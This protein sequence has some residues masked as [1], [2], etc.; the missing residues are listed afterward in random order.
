ML[1]LLQLLASLAL[2]FGGGEL[3][4]RG[5]IALASRL[6]VS[7]L[8]IGLTVVAFGT[9][10]PELVVS[11]NAALAGAADISVGNV[12]GS[13]IANIALILGLAALA[14]P[15]AVQA[16]LVRLDAPLM[17]GASVLALLV[18]GNGRAGRLEGG[19]LLAGLF[20]Y[21]VSTFHLARREARP[22]RD[23]L[24][25]AAPTRLPGLALGLT[26]TV[27]GLGLLI[28]GGQLLVRVAVDLATALGVSQAAIGL[29]IVA[30]GTSLPELVTSLLASLR[31]QGDIAVGNIVGSNL[32]N[33]LGILGGTA[34]VRPLALGGVGRFDLAAMLALAVLL[35]GLLR[36]R[37][38]LG[39]AAGAGLLACYVAYT[40]VLLA[41]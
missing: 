35:A 39:R 17:V 3:L 6:G 9:S 12:V 7:P 11:L 8:A 31:G 37:G 40:G 20:L 15:L 28:G 26:F 38:G 13:N 29:T 24:A 41:R 30:V 23:E 16:K 1:L 10:A 5:A 18:L 21:V 4:L 19:L 22:V 33:I 36:W 34:L 2:L 25:A 32:F 27:A 14:R